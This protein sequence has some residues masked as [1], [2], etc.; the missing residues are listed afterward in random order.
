M[1][2]INTPLGQIPKHLFNEFLKKTR[3]KFVDGQ[4]VYTT[5]L[6]YFDKEVEDKNGKK[7]IKE[8]KLWIPVRAYNFEYHLRKTGSVEEALSLTDSRYLP[9]EEGYKGYSDMLDEVRKL[10]VVNIPYSQIGEV[11]L[12]TRQIKS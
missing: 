6:V 12:Y 5:E 4:Y 10:Q 3:M 2:S 7:S 11:K 1:D 8:M 9:E